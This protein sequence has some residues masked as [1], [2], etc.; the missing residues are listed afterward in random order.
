M[1]S[2]NNSTLSSKSDY[3]IVVSKIIVDDTSQ[4]E[5]LI[6]TKNKDDQ[7]SLLEQRDIYG[8]CLLTIACMS[9]K[10]KSAVFFYKNGL[11]LQNEDKHKR[12][13]LYWTI[14]SDSRICLKWILSLNPDISYLLKRDSLGVTAF[15]VAASKQ[16]PKCLIMLLAELTK[17]NNCGLNDLTDNKKRTPLHYSAAAGSLECVEELLDQSFKIPLDAKDSNL[18]TPLMCAISNINALQVIKCLANKKS[19]SVSARNKS[20]A[21]ALH[22][23]VLANNLDAVDFLLTKEE[24]LVESFDNEERTPLHYACAAG[25]Y[26]IALLLIKFKARISV[27]DC[28]GATPAH[29]AAQIS[30]PILEKLL[31][32]A[33]QSAIKDHDDRTPLM[34]ATIAG[35]VSIVRNYLATFRNVEKEVDKQKYTALHFAVLS[36]SI[37]ICKLLLNHSFDINAEN[38]NGT[39]PMHLAAGRN[40]KILE[41]FSFYFEENN[42]LFRNKR[43]KFGR[44]PLFYAALG[45]QSEALTFLM[46]NNNQNI[47]EKDHF[48]KTI[49]HCAVFAK[50]KDC[51]IVAL[52]NGID[53]NEKDLNGETPLHV[54]VGLPGNADIVSLLLENRAEPNATTKDQYTPLHIAAKEGQEDVVQ[55]LLKFGANKALTTKKGF[56]PLHL[57]TKYGNAAVARLLF[58]K[59]TPVDIC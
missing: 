29:Y 34:W 6:K 44:S 16:S 8:R 14:V 3:E 43:D 26:E 4:L 20:G 11:R 23:A 10:P 7:R 19:I 47:L 51:V 27:W 57:A 52:N 36:G 58:E 49:L 2:S 35:K 25:R 46:E 13:V 5:K 39:T 33:T 56:T 40:I 31:K 50:S 42:D 54:A 12:N 9:D 55:I 30:Y 22:I 21:S 15:H 41:I 17:R 45:G 18:N 1:S 53:V 48:S 28:F 38:I 32:P 59:K 37:E 24:R